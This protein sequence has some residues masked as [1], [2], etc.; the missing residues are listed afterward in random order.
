MVRWE[1]TCRTG[2]EMVRYV[3]LMLGQDLVTLGNG[4]AVGVRLVSV[5]VTGGAGERLIHCSKIWRKLLMACSCALQ[6]MDG[7]SLMEHVKRFRTRVTL[8]SFVNNG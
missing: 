4:S 7:A 3:L 6:M 5:L 1:G 2:Q 8:S